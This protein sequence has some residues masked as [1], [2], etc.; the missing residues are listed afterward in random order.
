MGQLRKYIIQDIH[1]IPNINELLSYTNSILE[2][3]GE[4]EIYNA[5][6]TKHEALIK[7]EKENGG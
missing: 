6:R 4:K 5:I 7:K 3:I 1:Q 2:S